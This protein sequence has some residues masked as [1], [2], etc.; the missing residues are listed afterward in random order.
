MCKAI[1]RGMMR[2][3]KREEIQ[4]WAEQQ[5][6]LEATGQD[7]EHCMMAIDL[8][9]QEQETWEE[10]PDAERQ[11]LMKLALKVHVRAGHKPPAVLVR[12]PRRRGAPTKAICAMKLVSCSACDET[13]ETA[14]RPIFS[15]NPNGQP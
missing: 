11:R 10:V 8:N 3:P 9:Q 1:I 15:L 5:K 2:A 7:D 13:A 4:A 6:D 14:S 12:A